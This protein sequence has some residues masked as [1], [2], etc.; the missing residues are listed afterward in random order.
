MGGP[1]I[2]ASERVLKGL[3]KRRLDPWDLLLIYVD[4][5]RCPFPAPP[6]PPLQP[7]PWWAQIRNAR[8]LGRI[9]SESAARR[10]RKQ[11]G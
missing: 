1:R 9:Q 6:G 10:L 2:E 11:H 4:G 5:P 8:T 7:P 3:M